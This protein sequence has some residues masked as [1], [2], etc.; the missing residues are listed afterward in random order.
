MA[1]LPVLQTIISLVFIYL[2]LA[3]ITS[4]LQEY[5]A[6]LS[7]ARAKRLKQSI[8]KMLGEDTLK[9]ED[10]ENCKL[11][12]ST[13]IEDRKD[14]TDYFSLDDEIS[15]KKGLGLNRY[16]GEEKIEINQKCWID[17]DKVIHG[18]ND[19]SR[20]RTE[21]TSEFI[22][23]EDGRELTQSEIDEALKSNRNV[24]EYP[25]YVYKIKEEL[26]AQEKGRYF[27]KTLNAQQQIHNPLPVQSLTSKFY[28][29]PDIQALNQSA[30]NWWL[31]LLGLSF[32]RYPSK[33]SKWIT[34]DWLNLVSTFILIIAIVL[35]LGLPNNLKLISFLLFF[36]YIIIR[37]GIFLHLR[38]NPRDPGNL[39]ISVGP[40]YIDDA[41][42]FVKVLIDILK[43]ESSQKNLDNQD[44]I[45]STINSLG[46]YTPAQSFLR[47][48][49]S[50]FSIVDE[51]SFRNDLK[52][53]FDEVQTRSSGVY[54]RNAKGLSLLVGLLVAI[55]ANADT[56]N[57]VSKLNT[58]D[59]PN[60]EKLVSQLEGQY[61]VCIANPTAPA[62]AD[63]KTNQDALKKIFQSSTSLPLGW[64]DSTEIQEKKALQEKQVALKLQ[65]NKEL[66]DIVS[67][68]SDFKQD[69]CKEGASTCNP[70]S[71]IEFYDVKGGD[72]PSISDSRL[73]QLLSGF[74]REELQTVINKLADERLENYKTMPSPISENAS[75]MNNNAQNGSK[76]DLGQIDSIITKQGGWW[77]VIFGWIIT[78][79]ALSMGAPFWFD[80]LSRIMNVRNA[81]K[82]STPGQA[83]PAS[84]AGGSQQGRSQN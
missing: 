41:D 1:V 35:L 51:N 38:R 10:Q 32:S 80:L 6:T 31:P 70:K 2:A 73:K 27:L 11:C 39:R 8:L 66:K 48:R 79:I 13:G 84:S 5:L 43:N 18:V 25:V 45:Q 62:C 71:L 14:W 78:A 15:V 53:L 69:K 49:V 21:G 59:N 37:V 9:Q 33:V 23:I 30:F 36:L 61:T 26:P 7:E 74:T 20:I 52:R 29:H 17:D 56:F 76:Q 63:L 55:I 54:K 12:Y 72:R 58:P 57:M 19:V 81:A 46:F 34:E 75:N 16:K 40:S 3:L 77:R 50:R 83:P 65:K 60:T 22:S 28:L 44:N 67:L 82:E 4:E 42:L 64:D 24:K 47:E 68:L